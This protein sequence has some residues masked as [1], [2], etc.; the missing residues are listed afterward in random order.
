MDT[1]H[2]E[3]LGAASYGRGLPRFASADPAVEP[4]L[5]DNA[6]RDAAAWD[7]NQAVF[8]AWMRGW[9]RARDEDEATRSPA[10]ALKLIE[11]ITG[12][13][14]AYADPWVR[15]LDAVALGLAEPLYTVGKHLGDHQRSEWAAGGT[16]TRINLTVESARLAWGGLRRSQ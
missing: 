3:D 11:T 10:A 12:G 13:G 16:T 2:I 6:V 9:D 1:T 7:Y 4:L 15:Q 5:K 8:L 14:G